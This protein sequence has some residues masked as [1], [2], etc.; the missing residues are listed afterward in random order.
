MVA[1]LHRDNMIRS[2][3]RA[4]DNRKM[5]QQAD[6]TNHI[7]YVNSL[8]TDSESVRIRL[9]AAVEVSQ[10]FLPMYLISL[11]TLVPALVVN[12]ARG[13]NRTMLRVGASSGGLMTVLS[14]Y[15]WYQVF[16]V[17]KKQRTYL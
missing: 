16:W 14:C 5:Q 1:A 2:Q 10:V 17:E 15:F 4:S 6:L 3:Q 13:S 9:Q 8:P 11:A 7:N 12:F